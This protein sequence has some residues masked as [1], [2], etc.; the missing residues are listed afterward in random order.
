MSCSYQVVA[1]TGAPGFNMKSYAEEGR[2]V[3]AWVE[4]DLD[5]IVLSEDYGMWPSMDQASTYTYCG[6]NC[7]QGTLAERYMEDGDTWTRVNSQ[8]VLDSLNEKRKDNEIYLQKVKVVETFNERVDDDLMVAT[9]QLNEAELRPE[10][11]IAHELCVDSD[12]IFFGDGLT[13]A[14]EGLGFCNYFHGAEGLD[15]FRAKSKVP[16]DGFATKRAKSL[17]LPPF[18]GSS[19]PRKPNGI[20]ARIRARTAEFRQTR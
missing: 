20:S 12:E 18:H 16:V 13:N 11:R 5:K 17:T 15:P 10:G 6:V 2:L 3:I 14:F 9:C 7:G 19:H 4:Y 8:H 1:S